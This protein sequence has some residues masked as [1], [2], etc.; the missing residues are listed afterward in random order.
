LEGSIP[1]AVVSVKEKGVALNK[2]QYESL[3]Q[4]PSK[5]PKTISISDIPCCSQHPGTLLWGYTPER[6]S[7]H[8]YVFKN[9]L[10]LYV[11]ESQVTPVLIR[12]ESGDIVLKDIVPVKRLYPEA[13]NYEFCLQLKRLGL[14]LPFTTFNEDR[15]PNQY[16][17]AV[18]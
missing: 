10:H 5:P 16:Y 2:H 1:S 13:C 14:Y 15:E 8:V 12:Y 18:A 4:A 11:Y 3:L 6:Y 17:G 9:T 7:H